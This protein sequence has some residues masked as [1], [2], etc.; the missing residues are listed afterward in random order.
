MIPSE[1]NTNSMHLPLPH[2]YANNGYANNTDADD[3]DDEDEDDAANT[4]ANT[5][6][7]L[8]ER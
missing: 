5:V 2:E 6:H 1:A 8:D 7:W 4:A 3:T